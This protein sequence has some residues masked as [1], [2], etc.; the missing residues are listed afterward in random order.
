[1]R[2]LS[3]DGFPGQARGEEPANGWERSE[4]PQVFRHVEDAPLEEVALVV[5][6]Q[7]ELPPPALDR[8]LSPVRNEGREK[9]ED[10]GREND[11]EK[12]QP[13]SLQMGAGPSDEATHE[14]HIGTVSAVYPVPIEFG[15]PERTSRGPPAGRRDQPF[16]CLLFGLLSAGRREEPKTETEG[17]ARA[18][19]GCD[20][21]V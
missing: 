18:S 21:V 5:R 7:R 2:G 12:R 1:V 20:S 10:G 13:Q 14:R 8:R 15:A 19:P 6:A 16:F 9:P 4:E 11:E 3:V 17:A